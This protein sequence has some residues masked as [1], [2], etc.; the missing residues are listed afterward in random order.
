MEVATMKSKALDPNKYNR[1]QLIQP[2]DQKTDTTN[3]KPIDY[4][5]KNGLFVK[6]EKKQV[7]DVV[8]VDWFETTIMINLS[9]IDQEKESLQLSESIFLLNDRCRT[10][11]YLNKWTLVYCGEKV[12]TLMTNPD[13]SYM[14]PN[15]AQMKLENYLLYSIDWLDI[16]KDVLH[17]LK[18]IHKSL[19]RLDIAIDGS[20]VKNALKL[21]NDHDKG[22]VIG[23]K[24][25]ADFDWKKGHLKNVKSFIIGSAKSEKLATIYKKSDE[26]KESEKGYI[27]DFWTK[28]GLQDIEDTYRFEIRLRSKIA[29]NYDLDRLDQ[30]S[31]LSSIV[32][33]EI[34]NWFEFYYCGK[35]KNK[36]RTY[37]S[38]TM[39]WIDWENIKGE[40]LPKNKAILKT[41]IH[42]AKRLIKD[43]SYIHHVE[44]KPLQTDIIDLLMNEYCL[45]QWYDTRI[46]FWIE[47]FEKE[48]RFKN[49]GSN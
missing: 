9:K 34:K 23:R 44:G 46:D 5:G 31:Y 13:A 37:K 6:N 10:K 25:K 32:R 36:H 30:N 7:S 40:L 1:G 39:E 38:G 28:N 49:I 17:E 26:I 45:H 2:G 48:K 14:P 8:S 15:Q 19:T 29:N 11:H 12:A 33:S 21:V 20:S 16:Y 35:D 22:N 42:R 24:G 41:G 27:K 3:Y 18:W 47:D 43:L 4:N